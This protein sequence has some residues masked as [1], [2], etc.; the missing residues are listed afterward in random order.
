MTL[1]ELIDSVTGEDGG[2]TVV[3]EDENGNTYFIVDID[4]TGHYIS[5]IVEPS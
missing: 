2:R 4:T 5:I 3:V 1:D